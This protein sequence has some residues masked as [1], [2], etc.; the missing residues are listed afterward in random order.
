VTC[1]AVTDEQLR[2]VRFRSRSG[3][4][5]ESSDDGEKRSQTHGCSKSSVYI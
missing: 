3:N 4:R 1:R 5:S 2:A